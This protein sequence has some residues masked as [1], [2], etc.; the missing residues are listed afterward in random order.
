MVILHLERQNDASHQAHNCATEQGSTQPK[1]L[2]IKS[3]RLIGR[4]E[5]QVLWLRFEARR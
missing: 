2:M 4:C 1:D 3:Q 5:I